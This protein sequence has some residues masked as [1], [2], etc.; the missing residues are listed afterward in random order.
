LVPVLA[1]PGKGESMMADS[2]TEREI[3]E[4]AMAI[5]EIARSFYG[6]LAFGSDDPEVRAFCV[7]A[8]REEA[9]HFDT[10]KAILDTWHGSSARDATYLDEGDECILPANKR[11]PPN[12]VALHRLA[13]GGDLE[14]ALEMAIS[15]ETDAIHFY[16]GML[17]SFPRAEKTLH[18]TIV[19]EVSHLRN[20][21][22]LKTR[23]R[24]A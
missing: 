21:A 8:A 22:V 11:I 2:M 19:E 10:I 9:R 13:I 7:R 4:M 18:A 3:L 15:L 12:P 6:A 14:A 20:L 23:A 1:E 16:E 5:E 17:S 24:A